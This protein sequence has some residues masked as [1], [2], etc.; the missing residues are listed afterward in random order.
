MFLKG[1]VSVF[2][3]S[4]ILA[5]LAFS[6][7]TEDDPVAPSP[8]TLEISEF[9]W[10]HM[11]N[12]YL[13]KDMIPQNI[14]RNNEFDP[15]VLFEKLLFR[16]TDRWSFITDDYEA[17]VNSFKGIE[18][19]FGHHFKLF[20]LPNSTDIAGIVK[21]VVPDSP[22]DLAGI[23]RGDMFYKVNGGNISAD[24][25]YEL[26]FENETYNLSFGEFD[27]NGNITATKVKTLNSVVIAENP[28]FINKTIDYDGTKIGYLSYNQFIIDYN[29]ALITAFEK[30]K[31][32]GV[33]DLVLDLRY[34][35]GGS[36][37]AAILLSS[38][39]AP[40][41]VANNKEIYSKLIWN[42]DIMDYLIEEEGEESSNLTSKFIT[43][44]V[45]LN[46]N[47]IYILITRNSASASELVINCLKPYM[48]VILIGSENTT[49]KYVG[50]ITIDD[51]EADHGWAMQPIVLKTANANGIS[52]YADGFEPDY[53]IEDDF[54][55]PL[56]TLD[57]DMLAKS[58]ELI[59]G[60][61]ISDPARIASTAVPFTIR[62]FANAQELRKQT[63]YID[64]D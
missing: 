14:D 36:I 32:E 17:L 34:N 35:P 12:I 20:Y 10:E 29:N 18:K 23:K 47:R 41:N 44:E 39:I 43:P 63:M 27:Q 37:N 48:E 49:G 56:G 58:I 5:F 24:N 45:N 11:N 61:T 4:I 60:K 53:L 38:M 6:S 40:A 9:I 28:I 51:D 16:P 52:D 3:F 33:Q 57:E 55:A 1:R 19:S 7:C 62:S 30:F 31:N 26:L 8:Q 64:F 15:E 25:Y 59:T 54:N 22:A 21:Y 2:T 50:S 46:L 13:W 42:D